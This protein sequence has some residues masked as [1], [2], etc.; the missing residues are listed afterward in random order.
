MLFRDFRGFFERHRG[1]LAFADAHQCFEELR[2]VITAE[3]TG[4]LTLE[5]Y[6][7]LGVRQSIFSAEQR[8]L[9]H[10]VLPA[11]RGWLERSTLYEPNLVAHAFLSRMSPRYDFVAVDEVQDLTAVQ[12]ALVLKSLKAAGQFIVT[13]DA[14]QIVHPNFFSWAKV[15]TLFWRG[16]GLDEGR[17]VAVLDVSYR[18]SE[19]VTAVANN[20]LKLKHARFGSVDRESNALMRAVAGINGG[21]HGVET[22]SSGVAELDEN[23]RRSPRTAVVVLRDEDKAHARQH[24]HTPLVFSVHEA[25]GLEYENIILYRFVSGERRL[26]AELC[27]GV[28]DA[29]LAKET[30][31]YLRAKDKT[32]KSLEVYKF[33]VNALYVALTRAVANAWLVEDDPTHPIWKKL[34]VVFGEGGQQILV[35]E[36]SIEDWQAEAHRLEQQGKL[37]QAEAI[38][39]TVLRLEPVPWTVLNEAALAALAVKALDPQGVSNKARQQLLDYACFHRDAAIAHCLAAARFAPAEHY[40]Q[41]GPQVVRR[42]RQPYEARNFK[43]LLWQT[44][45]HGVDF[46]TPMNLTPLMA[47][48]YAGNARLVEALLARGARRELRDHLGHLALH[49]ALRRAYEDEA[50]VRGAP[51]TVYDV[52]ASPSFD[53]GR[54]AAGADRTG[55]GRVLRVSGADDAVV[56]GVLQAGP[57]C[58]LHGPPNHP[59]AL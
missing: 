42:L 7:S 43:D 13:G 41:Q 53:A 10:G 25:K 1:R 24:F 58:R 51:G 28:S 3:P 6:L 46:R 52:L 50:F 15:K 36:A 39:V 21:V 55:A 54:W 59:L 27:E 34:G 20:L 47:A 11:W 33:F 2:G 12:L 19:A 38:R 37:E 40:W 5:E 44:E 18:N 22:G 45:Q 32:D 49:W 14:N 26:F 17:D 9:L 4:V 30:L 35:A 8:A 29:A 16:I 56:Q 57:G 23:T 48:A 31:E